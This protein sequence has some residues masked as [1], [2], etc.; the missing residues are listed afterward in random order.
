MPTYFGDRKNMGCRIPPK[1]PSE[2][3]NLESVV[4]RLEE[5]EKQL[6][7]ILDGSLAPA[8]KFHVMTQAEYDALKTYEPNVPYFI[9]EQRFWRFGDNLPIILGGYGTALGEPF[10]II[11]T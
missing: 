9:V 3:G 8:P 1:R 4:H 7:G 6:A 11:L 2:A 10:P 5:A